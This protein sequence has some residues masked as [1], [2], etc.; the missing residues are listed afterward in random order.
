VFDSTVGGSSPASQYFRLPLDAY[1][2]AAAADTWASDRPPEYRVAPAEHR[3]GAVRGESAAV[4][5]RPWAT[6]RTTFV[7][8]TLAERPGEDA[9]P[10]AA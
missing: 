10:Q 5:A 9:P 1:T 2:T 3:A 6:G 8:G 4:F 7:N